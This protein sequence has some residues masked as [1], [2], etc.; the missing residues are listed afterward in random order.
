[1]ESFVPGKKVKF[2]VLSLSV[3][4]N[5]QKIFLFFSELPFP[6]WKIGAR[7]EAFSWAQSY[8]YYSGWKLQRI[9][10][11]TYLLCK[12]G[13]DNFACF[14]KDKRETQQQCIS[15]MHLSRLCLNLNW[16]NVVIVFCAC[17]V[18]NEWNRCWNKFNSTLESTAVV[19]KV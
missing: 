12:I 1:M 9:N 8:Y 5:L 19:F 6:F 10:R 16:K 13:W 14:E 7:I 15:E 11:P 18:K 2:L 4:W 17:R 3:Y